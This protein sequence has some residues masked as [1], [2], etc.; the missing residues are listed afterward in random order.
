ME[1]DDIFEEDTSTRS[2]L[3]LDQDTL[4]NDKFRI[5]RVLGVGGFG[6]T[7][8]AFDEVLEMVVAVKE[9]LPNDI[10]VRK[11]GSD[12]VQPLSSSGGDEK[13]FEYGLERFLQEARTLAKFERHPNIVRVRTFFEENG[14]AYLVMNFYRGRT[15]AEYLEARNGFLPEEEALLIM[16]QVLDGLGAVHEEGVLHRDIDPNNV[17]LADD[18]TV[19]LLDF[20]AARS[21]VGEQTQ[22]M[23][24]V[25]KRGYAPHEQY[26]SHG[27]QGP[28]TDIYACSATF[29]RSLTGYKPPEAAA[30]ILED[31]LAAPSELVPSLSDA[32]NDAIL[33]GLS[34]R[35][36]DRPQSVDDFAAL[37][38]DPPEETKPG[39]VGEPTSMDASS[40]DTESAAELQVTATHACRLYVDDDLST[41]LPPEETYTI[42]VDPGAHRLRAVRTDRA[43][44]GNATVTASEADPA[45]E[46]GSQLSIEA[47]MWQDAVTVSEDEPTTV[48][49]DF[50]EESSAEEASSGPAGATA[51]PG[52]TEVPDE[53]TA[54]ESTVPKEPDE[55]A[56]AEAPDEGEIVKEAAEPEEPVSEAGESTRE[57]APA[58]TLDPA[59]ASEETPAEKEG[60]LPEPTESDEEIAT[61]RVQLD[62][63]AR[64]FVDGDRRARIEAGAAQ[65]VMLSPGRHRVRAEATDGTAR[66]EQ[67]VDATTGSTQSLRIGL[68][69]TGAPER[70]PVVSKTTLRVAGVGTGVLL[71]LPALGWWLLSNEKPRP[72][73]DQI[74][75]TA[76]AAVV[77]V[78]ANDR[79][80]D[81]DRLRI[82]SV[83]AVPDSVAQVETVDSTR[84]R[85]RPAATF[86]GGARI[87][88]VAADAPGDTAHSS[89]TLRVPFNGTQQ[90]VTREAKQPQDIH[91][92]SL[93]GDGLDVA[94]AALDNR[95]VGRVPS[96]PSAAGRFDSLKVL[97]PSGDGAV[98]VH[99]A[100]LTGNDRLDVLSA[101]LRAD[102]V[103]W[104][105]NRGSGTFSS[106]Q[107]ITTA[108]DG[109]VSVQTADVDGDGDLDVIVG[110]LLDAQLLW[111]E[112]EGDG[113]FGPARL[114]ADS[115]RGLETLHI[116]DLDNDDVPDVL[117]VSY[118][119]SVIYR[120]EPQHSEAD[121]VRFTTG[122][123]LPDLQSG[124][125]DVNT[126]DVTGNG[127]EDV[128]I[129]L[130]GSPSVFV[131]E[132][133][134]DTTGTLT[135][136]DRQVLTSEVK[137][138]E[139][140][141]TG[142]V[143]GDGRP[144]LVAGSFDSE[145]IVWFRNEGNGAFTAAQPLAADVPEVLSLEVADLTGDGSPDVLAASQASDVVL[146][147]ENHLR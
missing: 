78:T 130:D 53:T 54:G 52:D 20:G 112:N 104:Y 75:T 97:D 116:T 14:T 40:A 49:V 38:P 10:A 118:R 103:T 11:T 141:D 126:A 12:T 119:D 60:P 62:R 146:W 74:V 57:A 15:L 66:W 72:T 127:W 5:G 99:A 105:E 68:D 135:F 84:L 144:D 37:L 32:T 82:H 4:L 41:E 79:D 117:A 110:S 98:D 31:E 64:L 80:P 3:A 67:D 77:D 113:T 111:Y 46:E 69:R 28:W 140:I 93:E 47:L 39:W 29:Y 85:I 42:A 114:F 108:V 95:T 120:F 23:S 6:I 90:V 139:G 109:P 22:S 131:V 16:D 51:A 76:A 136:G 70:G 147:Y 8:L 89:V 13:G 115:V 145:A 56:E 1:R 48:E 21:A 30:R 50:T 35:P 25:L 36:D 19:V 55:A 63:S 2:P 88:Y 96:A 44:S 91:A 45:A 33:E 34:V 58:P 7:Y 123:A 138:V 102:A 101:S 71:L 129:G 137:T 26:H 125:I 65:E 59:P 92:A 122:P 143:D 94:V 132:N 134:T 18:G 142:D 9:Y 83:G 86:A 106:P 133:Q 27:D 81:G 24:V 100:D 61:L 87:P 17:Y 128:L 43:S 121:S 107:S 73:P 124:P